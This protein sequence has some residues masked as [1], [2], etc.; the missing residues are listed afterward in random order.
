MVTQF[1]QSQAKFNMIDDRYIELLFYLKMRQL[2]LRPVYIFKNNIRKLNG[3]FLRKLWSVIWRN[4]FGC[5]ILYLCLW[6]KNDLI[7]CNCLNLNLKKLSKK[8]TFVP[9]PQF[10]R[11]KMATAAL[12]FGK[13]VLCHIWRAPICNR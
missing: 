12:P 4:L 7:P 5:L 3:Q 10:F 2:F 13:I 9:C 6:D 8:S 11:F 1:T